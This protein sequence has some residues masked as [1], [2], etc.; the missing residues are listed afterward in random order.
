MIFSD[1]FSGVTLDL[2]KWR[3]NWLGPSDT[4]ITQ[5]VNSEEVSC[6]DPQQV[7][8]QNG[9]LNL[10]AIQRTCSNRSY[11][12][13]LIESDGNFNFTYGYV[14]AKIWTPTGTGMWPAFWTD[15]QNWP[16]DGE[17]DVLEAYGTDLST[18]H[19]HYAGCGGDC[20]PGGEVNVPG[21]T[22]GW[23]VYAAKWEP[24]VMTWYYDGQQVWQYSTS[25]VSS[26]H[27]LIL[28]LG[29]NSTSAAVP[30][31]MRVDYVRVWQSA[32][33]PTPV[34]P[35]MT[36]TSVL[37]TV[38]STPS[39]TSLPKTATATTTLTAT[40]VPTKTSTP[41]ST[42]T[43]TAATTL[44]A[45]AVPTK[46]STPTSTK[47]AT[48]IPPTAT[49]L[50]ATATTVPVQKVF[51]VR[52]NK[53]ADDVE[54]YSTGYMSLD[55]SDLEL[56]YD[57]NIQKVGIRFVNVN[58]PKGALI[59]KAYLQFKVDETSSA[60]TPL[61]IIGEAS[62][63][64]AAFTTALGN[65]SSRLKTIKVVG[66][67]PPAWPTLK[68]AGTDQRTPNVAPII[69]EIVNQ[70]GWASGNS[71]VMIIIGNGSGKRVGEAYEVDPAGAPLLHVEYTV[72]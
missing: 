1:E 2:S 56:V 57:V 30:A 19:Y 35:T 25:I 39:L 13:G 29:L 43:A 18:F 24:G 6:Y 72:K 49:G 50:P 67:S 66:W 62:P 70:S 58:I 61:T 23:H 45:T 55:S 26:P 47:T 11:A 14:E 8:V 48:K 69:Q 17:M 42:K 44:T 5:P 16:T 54:E 9:E 65:I 59:T 4:S 15:G 22:T 60:T 46:S 36:A 32:P 21:A 27:Y 38:T 37:S 68:A 28:N 34:L 41:T 52:V 10:T 20:G 63:N 53:G 12:S 71:L 40:A 51:D 7:T 31:T 33:T 3:P 64:A